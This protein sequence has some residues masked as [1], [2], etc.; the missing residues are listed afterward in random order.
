ML[1]FDHALVMFAAGTIYGFILRHFAGMSRK[2][3][4]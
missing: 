2:E 1:D 4:S 3:K